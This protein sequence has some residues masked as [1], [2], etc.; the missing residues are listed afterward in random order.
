MLG[1]LGYFA[2]RAEEKT[3]AAI[4][5]F[6]EEG[7]RLLGVMERRLTESAY[8]GG[9]DYSIADIAAYPWTLAATTFLQEPLAQALQDKEAI[10]RWL[11]M[12][13]ERPAVQRGMAV[14]K[15]A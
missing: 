9:E 13:G 3:P 6:T 7:E 1:Q 11:Q 2:R 4:A 14:P 5:R 12:V 15:V 10:R 8:L